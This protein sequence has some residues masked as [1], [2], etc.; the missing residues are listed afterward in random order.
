MS[1]ESQ[2]VWD[3]LHS[4]GASIVCPICGFEQ[5]QGFG[6]L[7]NLRVMLPAVLPTGE[8][9]R[10]PDETGGMGAYVYSCARCGFIRLHAKQVVDGEFLEEAE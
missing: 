1:D 4:R 5:W 8:A 7:G 6:D 3:R 10:L 9:M 2:R